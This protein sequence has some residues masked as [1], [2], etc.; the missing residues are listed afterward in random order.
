MKDKHTKS[1]RTF[2]INKNCIILFYQATVPSIVV[3]ELIHTKALA[4]KCSVLNT[5][6][7]AHLS[8]N[9]N[10]S[11][12]TSSS[13]QSLQESINKVGLVVKELTVRWF[14]NPGSWQHSH[15]ILYSGHLVTWSDHSKHHLYFIS[16]LSPTGGPSLNLK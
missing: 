9:D 14:C 11:S 1:S 5:L 16:L 4:K 8:S 12:P 2:P 15:M 6:H 10:N 7:F 13:P 3:K